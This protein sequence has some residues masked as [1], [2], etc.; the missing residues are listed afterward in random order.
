MHT[1]PQTT[2][3]TLPAAYV[4]AIEPFAKVAGITVD[5]YVADILEPIF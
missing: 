5:Q 1:A 2:T 4:A 3:I